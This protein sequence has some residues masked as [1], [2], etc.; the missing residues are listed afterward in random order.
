MIRRASTLGAYPTDSY[1]DPA[2]PAW[3]P[4]WVD[5]PTESALKYQLYPNVTTVAPLPAP[6][7][8]A[9]PG[10]PVTQ[11]QMTLPGAYTPDMSAMQAHNTSV[12]NWTKFFSDLDAAEKARQAARGSDWTS[13]PWLL[14]GGLALGALL[15]FKVLR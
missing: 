4:Y 1:Y 9:A 6:P 3:L 12:A 14:V 7:G 15:I 5:S 13:S 10:A 2:R 8:G 11:Q